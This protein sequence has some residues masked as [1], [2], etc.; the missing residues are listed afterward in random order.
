ME[1]TQA[2]IRDEVNRL[3][4]NKANKVRQVVHNV[5]A[6]SLPKTKP[7]KKSFVNTF[8]AASIV[9][10]MLATMGGMILK[11]TVLA[12]NHYS[13]KDTSVVVRSNGNTDV[14]PTHPH[15]DPDY[16]SLSEGRA[17]SVQVDEINDKMKVWVHRTWLL[18]LAVNENAHNNNQVYH[19]NR[20]SG[21]IQFDEKWKMNKIPESM[22]LTSEQRDS[23]L[24][25]PK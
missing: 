9:L 13:S 18:G 22:S 2:Y 15:V 21:F 14:K 19:G 8:L 3:R 1:D 11:G 20:N 6:Q 4:A 12:N 23:I 7:Q 25:G 10:L 17:L 5:K 16:M 24:N